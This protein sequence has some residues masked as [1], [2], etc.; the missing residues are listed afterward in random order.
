MHSKSE[1]AWVGGVISSHQNGDDLVFS[2]RRQHLEGQA[3]THEFANA[4]GSERS[5][6]TSAFDLF[7][8][9]NP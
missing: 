1:H 3:V 8:K 2:R 9:K 4:M 5:K 7:R 6:P